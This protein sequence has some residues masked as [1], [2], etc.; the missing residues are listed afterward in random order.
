MPWAG[1]PRGLTP[2][3]IAL[4]GSDRYATAVIV[5]KRFFPGSGGAGLA[6]GVS[7]PDALA[8]GPVLGVSGV[9]LLLTGSTSLASVTGGYLTT[10]KPLTVHMFGGTAALSAGVTAA[11]WSRLG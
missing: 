7:F 8:A 10:A 11:V 5:A 9:P 1:R 2:Q 3:A 4:V 6:S